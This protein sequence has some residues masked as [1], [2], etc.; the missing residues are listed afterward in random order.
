MALDARPQ[1][2][3][4]L[5]VGGLPPHPGGTAVSAAGLLTGLAALGHTVRALAPL[6]PESS[7]SDGGWL[8]ADRHVRVSRFAVSHY[9]ITAD[10]PA[11]SAYRQGQR[12]A[13]RTLLPAMIAAEPPDVLFVG[14]ETFVVDVADIA[15]AHAIPCLLRLPGSVICGLLRGTYSTGW[16]A[17]CS[18]PA[19]RCNGWSPPPAISPSGPARSDGTTSSSSPTPSTPSG[20]RRG[21]RTRALLR[22]HGIP[23]TALVVAHLSNLKPIKQPLDVV[24]SARAVLPQDPRLVYL[25]VGDG[26]ARRPMEDA[27]QQAGIQD[28]VRFT[29]WVDYPRVPDYINLADLVVMPSADE[30]LARVY[31]ETQACG[32]VLLASDIPPPAKSSSTVR[33]ACSSDRSTSRTSPRPPFGPRPTPRSAPRSAAKGASS[34]PRPAPSRRRRGPVRRPPGRTGPRHHPTGA[35]AGPYVGDEAAVA[36]LPLVATL[37]AAALYFSGVVGILP[38]ALR[39]D[40]R[41]CSSFATTASAGACACDT[42]GRLRTSLRESRTVPAPTTSDRF[43][44]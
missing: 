11:T 37:L 31:L 23:D 42:T 3:S 9:D 17:S 14:R 1:S 28:R 16:P 32:R 36:R 26:P 18:P 10:I 2:L 12:D 25:I 24:A 5:Y 8:F 20:S 39:A 19:A 30:G 44:R 34:T 21:R 41:A 27:C 22:Q 38:V 29:G 13:I 40:F 15:R 35:G 4:V 7:G 6:T 33:P 43:R